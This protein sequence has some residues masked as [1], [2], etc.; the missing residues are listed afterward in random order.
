MDENLS[1]S[2][3]FSLAHVGINCENE[4]EAQQTARTLCTLFGLDY[5]P[6]GKSIFA[7]SIVE[8]MKSPYLGKSGHIAIATNDLERA[9]SHLGSQGVRFNEDTRTP[10][11]IYLKDEVGGFAIHLVQK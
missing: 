6:G 7:G 8:C 3:G 11:A 2:L 1:A 10:K 4:A 5:K 9:I